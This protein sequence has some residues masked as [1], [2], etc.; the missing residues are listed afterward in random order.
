MVC[1]LEERGQGDGGKES[2]TKGTKAETVPETSSL[3]PEIRLTL[4]TTHHTLSSL[5]SGTL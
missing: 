2:I 4:G 1:A 3:Q 5:Y